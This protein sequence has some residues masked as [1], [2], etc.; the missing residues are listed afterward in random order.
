VPSNRYPLAATL[1]LPPGDARPDLSLAGYDARDGV[2]SF[3]IRAF[4]QSGCKFTQFVVQAGI[5]RG[6]NIAARGCA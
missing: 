6:M 2:L 5:D 1:P 3:V 4:R